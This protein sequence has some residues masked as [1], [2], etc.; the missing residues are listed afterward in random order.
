[1]WLRVEVMQ[2]RYCVYPLDI[3]LPRFPVS[4]THFSTLI[5]DGDLLLPQDPLDPARPWASKDGKITLSA[6]DVYNDMTEIG[7]QL[8]ALQESK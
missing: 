6:L 3:L 2:I 7:A 8:A 5:K 4:G 1:M